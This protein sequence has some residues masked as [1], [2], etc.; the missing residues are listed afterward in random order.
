MSRLALGTVQFGLPYGIANRR[1]QVTRGEVAAILGAAWAGGITTLDTAAMYGDSE[2]RL[3]AAG[4]ADFAVV[5]KLPPLPEDCA[6]PA[7]WVAAQLD[8]ALARLRL[9]RLH[10]ML[11]HRP[12]QLLGGQGAALWQGLERARAA[13]KVAKIGVS[14][15]NP[16]ELEPLLAQFDIDLVQAPFNLVDQRLVRSGWLARLHARGVEVHCRSAF[17]QGLLLM[18]RAAIPAQFAPWSALWAR[19]HDWQRD[20]GTGALAAALGFA[21]SQPEISRVVVGVDGLAQ[22]QQILMAART[23]PPETWPDLACDTLRLIDPSQWSA[24]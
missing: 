11:L 22:V 12:A 24:P 18:E 21:L 14:I 2:A 13:G 6:A 9:A 19:W 10:G 17:L 1:G 5:T 15:Y 23:P 8:A 20:T 4:V 3:G 16:Q 7:A